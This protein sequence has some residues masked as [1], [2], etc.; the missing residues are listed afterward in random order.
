MPTTTIL[1]GLALAVYG[2]V[3]WLTSESKSPTAL[4]PAFFGAA[5]VICG[6]VAQKQSLRKHA[7]HLAAVIGL[8]GF[9]GGAVMGF[10]KVPAWFAGELDAAGLNKVKS[11]CVLALTCLVFVLLCVKSFIDAR[12]ARRQGGE[13]RPPA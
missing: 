7:M 3:S 11:Q 5:F 4:I 12:T 13:P 8:I 2:F 10:P 1:F 9:I 6:L